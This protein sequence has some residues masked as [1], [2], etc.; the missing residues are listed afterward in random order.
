MLQHA[1]TQPESL[2]GADAGIAKDHKKDYMKQLRIAWQQLPQ[3]L[4][5]TITTSLKALITVGAFYLLLTHEVR[6]EDGRHVTTLRAIQEHIPEID[7]ATFW[8]FCLAATA[9]KFV[10]I[11]SSMYRW[12][13]L[14]RGQG[15][16]LPFRHIFGSFLIGRFIGTFLPSTLGLDGYKLY[17]AARF[18]GRAVEA[19]AATVIEK[20]L[21]VLGI[22]LTFLV[23]LPLGISIFG[24]NAF[25]VGILTVPIA[26]GI[27]GGFFLLLFKPALVQWFIENVPFPGK[28]KIS[29]FVTRVS[30]AAAAYSDHK[31][32][33][34]NATFQSWVVHFT[35]AAMYYFTALA[36]GAIDA[37]FWEVTFASVIQIFATV[38]SPFTIA[39]EGIRE[40]AQT[41]LLSHRL[42]TSQAVMSAALGFWAAEALTLGGAFFWWARRKDYRPSYVMVD[43]RAIDPSTASPGELGLS[44]VEADRLV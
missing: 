38:V 5:S 2:C 33:L 29:G 16:V 6:T 10:G 15:I 7:L 21:G 4:R 13:L 42:G 41:Y 14:L 30:N 20:V 8:K 34:L 18:S 35:T 17:D 32:I 39:G 25:Q 26:T 1:D 22:F 43:G 28:A 24:D 23:A 36:V 40:I 31:M 37:N 3:R 27:I 44:G 19:T 11:L 9:I 12:T